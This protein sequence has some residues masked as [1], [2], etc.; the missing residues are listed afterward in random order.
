MSNIVHVVCCNIYVKKW[1]I[2]FRKS[3]LHVL[4]A[5]QVTW[6][7]IEDDVK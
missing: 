2:L 6:E 5:I 3:V 1:L 7:P 4:D